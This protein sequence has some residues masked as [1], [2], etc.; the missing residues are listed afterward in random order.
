MMEVP[1]MASQVTAMKVENEREEKAENLCKTPIED[2]IREQNMP[3]PVERWVQSSILLPTQYLTTMVYYFVYVEANP[4]Q[5]VTN[6]G[7]ADLFKL[8]PRN[9]HCLVSGKKYFRGSHGAGKKASMLKE[10]E[11]HGEKMVK[12]IKC[13]KKTTRPGAAT[14]G[15]K[16]GG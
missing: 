1:Q 5:N 4:K 7:V 3:T 8:S 6:K 14:G 13:I 11:E 10:L 9:L 15:T 2:I 16:N 12:C